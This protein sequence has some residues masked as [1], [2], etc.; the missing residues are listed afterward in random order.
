MPQ[1]TPD[2]SQLCAA[3]CLRLTTA[4]MILAVRCVAL[5]GSIN[6]GHSDAVCGVAKLCACETNACFE[7]LPGQNHG[8]TAVKKFATDFFVN[9]SNHTFALHFELWWCL[10]LRVPSSLLS[11]RDYLHS[12]TQQKQRWSILQTC[13]HLFRQPWLGRLRK[14]SRVNPPHKSSTVLIT[15]FMK[16]A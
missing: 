4:I 14:Q 8:D 9:T 13:C 3:A 15:I 7:R 10:T 12:T 1:L 16:K 2:T 5:C 6:V 11:S